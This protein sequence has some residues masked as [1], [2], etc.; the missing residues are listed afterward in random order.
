MS[1]FDF[2]VD[3]TVGGRASYF[4]NFARRGGNIPPMD[5]ERVCESQK[6]VTGK[7][8]TRKPLMYKSLVG[9]ARGRRLTGPLRGPWVR[10]NPCGEGPLQEN[11][12]YT[13]ASWGM[14]YGEGPLQ[15]C[16]KGALMG[17]ILFVEGPYGNWVGICA[18]ACAV[19]QKKPFLIRVGPFMDHWLLTGCPCGKVPYAEASYGQRP[20]FGPLRGRA[21]T[22]IGWEFPLLRREPKKA[23]SSQGWVA[24]GA[25]APYGAPLRE[26]HLKR[27][28]LGA[29]SLT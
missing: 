8:L 15:G 14:S 12:L 16:C 10:K 19:D 25:L 9:K 21:L 27:G 3:L 1:G 17:K 29:R 28:L 20:L 13:K 4:R 5:Q 7:P 22:G 18:C 26:S 2:R 23:I 24:Y 6:P 11:P